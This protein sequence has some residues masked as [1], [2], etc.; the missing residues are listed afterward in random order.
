MVRWVIKSMFDGVMVNDEMLARLKTMSLRGPLILVPCHKSHMD[1]LILSYVLYQNNLPC[2]L[3]AAGT[4]L[5]FWPI[6]PLFRGGGAFFIRR[7]FRGAVLYSKVFTEYIE[8]LLEEGFNIEFFIEGG[9]SRTGKLIMPKLGLLSILLNGM[10]SGACE[11]LIFAPIYI[12]YDQVLEDSAY[13][14]ELEGG[15][16]KPE[17]FWQG[18]KARKFLKKRYG[19]IYLQFQEP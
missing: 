8:K 4:N 9:R 18:L 15:Q 3:V 17:S 16:K 14:E 19:K 1:Y 13:L 2:P 5:S 6:G 10:K 12:G 11:D 7:S